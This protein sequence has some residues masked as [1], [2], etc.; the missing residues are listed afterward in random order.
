MKHTKPR[1]QVA[2]PKRA[3]ASCWDIS[4]YQEYVNALE[5]YADYLE[6]RLKTPQQAQF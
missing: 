3:K 1:Q 4:R 6:W 5:R 2:R